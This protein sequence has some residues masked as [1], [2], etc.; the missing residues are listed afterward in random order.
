MYVIGDVLYDAFF[1]LTVLV[2]TFE[3]TCF[4]SR[5]VNATRIVIINAIPIIVKSIELLSMMVFKYIC[6]IAN[7]ISGI[8]MIKPN[9]NPTIGTL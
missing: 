9:A 7:K 1:L 8:D 5:V 6:W 3:L 2:Y 4:K